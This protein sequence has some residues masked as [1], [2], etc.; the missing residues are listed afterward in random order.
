MGAAGLALFYGGVAI[1][2]FRAYRAVAFE[3]LAAL[4]AIGVLMVVSADLHGVW[5]LV[6]IDV[7]LLVTLAVEQIRIERPHA[8]ET[9]QAESVDGG[10]VGGEA[11]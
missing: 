6:G 1:A 2:V 9:A 11:G 5:L 4:V 7:I 3:R 10:R 8:P